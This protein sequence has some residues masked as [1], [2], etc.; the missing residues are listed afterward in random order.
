VKKLNNVLLSSALAVTALS[1][2]ASSL[3]AQS[4]AFEKCQS[5]KTLE[6]CGKL[7]E[8]PVFCTQ[9]N[10]VT[11]YLGIDP[12]A[13]GSILFTLESSQSSPLNKSGFFY[14]ANGRLRDGA[15]KEV[16]LS[17]ATCSSSNGINTC[18]GSLPQ[19]VEAKLAT[20]FNFEQEVLTILLRDTKLRDVCMGKLANEEQTL[21][22]N[23]RLERQFCEFAPEAAYTSVS[24]SGF[25]DPNGY[26]TTGDSLLHVALEGLPT[27]K[28]IRGCTQLGNSYQEVF[29]LTSYDVAKGDAEIYGTL[30]A[31]EQAVISGQGLE[32]SYDLY[33]QLAGNS[34]SISSLSRSLGLLNRQVSSNAASTEVRES[35]QKFEE[36]KRAQK[37]KKEEEKKKNARSFPFSRLL[38]ISSTDRAANS[39]TTEVFQWLAFDPN[40][41][42]DVIL[43]PSCSAKSVKNSSY[44]VL[45]CN[46]PNSSARACYALTS[47]NPAS[48]PKGNACLEQ[49]NG[50][51]LATIRVEGAADGSYYICNNGSLVTSEQLNVSTDS[52]GAFGELQIT[53]NNLAAQKVPGLAEGVISS[54]DTVTIGTA[55]DCS[56]PTL[57]GVVK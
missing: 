34:G 12:N 54:L 4:P 33:R 2:F 8:L 43:A 27:G 29:S 25:F 48:S 52:L 6:A 11:L 41:G 21:T 56:A 31:D 46:A 10:D 14:A 18:K 28:T 23:G 47:T 45:S 32:Y 50:Y 15:V 24:G 26:G 38:S 49:R 16:K 3:R 35:N 36:L 42:G 19:A 55:Q 51:A 20:T 39:K 7:I 1:A 53:D 40:G 30:S 57:Q 22:D 9:V 37:K 44:G 13:G 5:E 17:K